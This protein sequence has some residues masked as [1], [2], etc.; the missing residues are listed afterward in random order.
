MAKI[1][2]PDARAG[3]SP[4]QPSPSRITSYFR[5]T[6]LQCCLSARAITVANHPRGNGALREK[7][8]TVITESWQF[9]SPGAQTGWCCTQFII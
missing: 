9:C 8:K 2:K 5:L 1:H 6:C 4:S 7:T 3:A